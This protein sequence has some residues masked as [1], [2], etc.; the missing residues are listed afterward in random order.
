M[1]LN[2][3]CGFAAEEMTPEQD[4]AL[5]AAARAARRDVL[6]M[7]AN[8]G[9]G[10]VGGSLSSLDVY[11]LLLAGIDR[12]RGDRLVVSHGH[13]AAGIYAAL[14]RCGFFDPEAAVE[15][16]R[17]DGGSFEG[18]PSLHVPGIEWTSGS[19][20]QG[21]SVGC[22]MAL[23]ARLRKSPARIYV[24][25]GD[26]E[27][28]KGQIEEA[29]E[30]AVKYQL[31]NLTGI[32]DCNGLQASGELDA[33]MPQRIGE[34]YRAAGWTV[35]EADGH[36]FPALYRTLRAAEGKKSPVLILAHTVMG[37]G[38]PAIENRF[39]YH[40]KV[41]APELWTGLFPDDDRNVS[42]PLP[43]MEC[44]P[45]SAPPVEPG[46][47]REYT[48]PQDCRSA[49]GK[50]L[51]DLA[52]ANPDVPLAALDCDLL[53]SVKLKELQAAHPEKVI[54]CGIQ[55]HNAATVAAALSKSGIL[56]FWADFGVFGIDEVYSQLRMADFNAASLKL[57]C[58]HV[59]LDVGE[60]GKT[61]QCIDYISLLS[62]LFGFRVI[63]P[64]D[65]NQAD[66]AV[67]YAARTPG[68]IA[69][70]M[71][72]S[73]LPILARRDGTL[74]YDRNCGFVYGKADW[75]REGG[76]AAI[77]ACGSTVCRA[78]RAADRLAEAGIAAGVLNVPCPNKFD[79]EAVAEACRT[80]CVIV[81]EDHNVRTGLGT[82][83]GAA[84]LEAGYSCRFKRIGVSSY[85]KS[86]SPE[87]LFR[88]QGLDEES[89]CREIEKQLGKETEK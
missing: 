8:A 87:F 51:L 12:V 65:A 80:G 85:G 67:R 79:A 7:V 17:R 71:G 45:E 16:F 66:R 32:V 50:A 44:A 60:D 70:C 20:G 18:H 21:L 4:E 73:R 81:C 6:R 39:E 86:A 75:L 78:V 27:Q 36:D 83:L 74:C 26:G 76:D 28:A 72:R 77:V 53:E 61:H 82:M 9:S 89:L 43:P 41:P 22:G 57:V 15:G 38:V 88:R 13:T 68:N 63:V 1:E 49:F 34:K 31:K 24:A 56:T 2:S 14:G 10:H 54:E 11:L 30:F 46:T 62:N 40:G 37:K 5:K 55:E 35:L 52:E 42:L 69:V 64:A 19:L 48:E 59:G 58:T 25:M 84:I 33:V 47:P 29:R 3:L 23:A